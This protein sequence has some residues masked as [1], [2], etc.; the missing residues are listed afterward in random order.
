[1]A[2]EGFDLSELKEALPGTQKKTSKVS[3]PSSEPPIKLLLWNI[4]GSTSTGMAEAHRLLLQQVGKK[5][6]PDII[7][8]Q[9]IETAITVTEFQVSM[10]SQRTYK[11]NH[12][13]E[14]SEAGIL[15][16]DNR[17]VF[18]SKVNLAN[19]LEGPTLV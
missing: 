8:L 15:Y 18:D 9:E 5:T 17:F 1:M 19:I 7:L 14:E 3:E 2:E 10:K 13:G 16:D 11:Y 4:H 6:D 12:S